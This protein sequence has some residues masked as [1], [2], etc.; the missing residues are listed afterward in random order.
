MKNDTISAI[1]SYIFRYVWIICII[2]LIVELI[3]TVSIANM[4][5]VKT[6]EDIMVATQNEIE[7]EIAS[8]LTLAEALA[9]DY[10]IANPDID[11]IERGK[12]LKPYAEAYNLFL[13]GL[14]N[15][16]GMIVSSYDDIPGDIGYRDYFQRV[17]ATGVPE[18]TDAF[19]A[20]ADGVTKNY[21]IC[22]PYFDDDQ[23][24]AGTIIMS[25]DYNKL[26]SI[27][28]RALE[29]NS[30]RFS[31]M[32]SENKIM[33]DQDEALIG[34]SFLE[35]EGDSIIFGTDKE[36]LNQTIADKKRGSYW[37]I[38]QGKLQYVSYAPIK[39]TNW[40]LNVQTNV[41]CNVQPILYQFLVKAC[42]Y[43]MIFA[44]IS[45]FGRKYMANKLKDTYTL[46][47]Q[48]TGLQYELQQQ[49][50]LASDEISEFIDVYQ[51]GLYDALTQLPT[52]SIF[53]KQQKIAFDLAD[54][55][56]RTAL[57]AVDL[58]HLKQINDEYGHNIGDLSLKHIGEC[59]MELYHGNECLACRYGG[60]EFLAFLPFS[61]DSELHHILQRLIVKL[62]T[63][64]QSPEAS[65]EISASI[66]VAIC[67]IHG[68]DFETLYRAADS[69]LYAAKQEGRNC[70]MIYDPSTIYS[71]E[72]IS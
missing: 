18:I 13:I 58:D 66:G 21:T 44:F 42:L 25:I 38:Y 24:V 65:I 60:D 55:N 19:L 1:M 8:T 10:I 12:L 59:L 32:D 43:I 20:G 15:R 14:T 26:N 56:Q 23:E 22:M 4:L 62:H 16:Q 9:N 69:A 40:S 50:I 70:F 61:D 53:L 37:E 35:A 63:T 11:L 46:I 68:H 54:I 67:P 45:F 72:P 71:Q 30:Y 17:I 51:K 28:T 39:Y 48:I 27:A 33:S 47:K 34:Q 3:S 2:I 57:I 6:T 64:I 31:L 29:E 49:N 36:A 41:F 7:N 52:R 5:M